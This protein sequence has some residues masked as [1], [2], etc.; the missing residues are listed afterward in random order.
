MEFKK[1]SDVEVVAEPIET[2]N[3][4]I[5]EDGVIKKAPKTAVGGGNECTVYIDGER[6]DYICGGD[7]MYYEFNTDTPTDTIIDLLS[8]GQRVVV[9]FFIDDV[10]TY[11][12]LTSTESNYWFGIDDENLPNAELAYVFSLTQLI[13]IEFETSIQI[14]KVVICN[15]GRKIYVVTKHIISGGVQ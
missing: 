9:R 2:A 10:Y 13:N 1:L 3:V 12:P 14:E 7:I 4:L 5:E 6:G 15:D 8:K 11:L